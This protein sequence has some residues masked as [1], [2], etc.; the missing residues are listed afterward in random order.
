M[1][2]MNYL[3]TVMLL[4]PLSAWALNLAEPGVLMA[5]AQKNR[6]ELREVLLDIDMN[7]PEM[8]DQPTFEKYFYLL[9]SLN[10]LAVKYNLDEIYPKM[11]P[12]LGLRMTGNGMRWLDVTK[13]SSEKLQYY[14][15]WMDAD[16]LSRFLDN[17]TYNLTLIK[18]RGSLAVMAT[19]IESILPL[20]DAKAAGQTHLM[21]GYRRLLTDVAIA[22]LRDKTLPAD[23]VN[24]WIGK[25][26]LPSSIAEYTDYLS[27]DIYQLNGENKSVAPLY[28][29]RLLL[30]S[31]Q[32]GNLGSA[33][34]QWLANSLG[35]AVT[36]L[37]LRS[38][39]LEIVFS[40]NQYAQGLALLSG[41]QTIG[42][43]QQLMAQEKPPRTQFVEQYLTL[44]NL[45]IARL[46]SLGLT[47]D[48]DL[49]AKWLAQT[50]APIMAQK[51]NLEGHYALV[52]ENGQP[53]FFTVALAK[54]NMLVAALADAEGMVFKNFYNISFNLKDNGF[55]ASERE[56]DSDGPQNPPAKF[57]IN[58]KGQI[59]LTDIFVRVGSGRFKGQKVQNFTDIWA[60]AKKDA[61]V[62]DG[63]YEGTM[64]LPSG[65]ESKTRLI[66]TSFNGYTTGR[67]EVDKVDIDL[68][69]GTA[70]DDGAITLTSGRKQGASWL[71]VRA[72]IT[73]KGLKAY[74]IVGGKGQGTACTFLKKVN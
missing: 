68:N 54:E 5:K 42:F 18:D 62:P 46:K 30:L 4:S 47:K 34:P 61:P 70:G 59:Q 35:D 15:K 55:V 37:L 50:A 58:E 21:S 9:D 71:Q 19:N 63:I 73:E 69:I 53:W 22:T 48:A 13:D 49:H 57:T 43:S 10:A 16:V 23:E 1:K 24:F 60:S 6:I 28:L 39:R 27:Q 12:R 29:N 33:A 25:L 8:R 67:L 52:D 65:T 17:T 36:E 41:R 74:L 44:S 26:M 14:V 45:L 72:Q 2:I 38:V 64:F 51:V 66:I 32:V 11:V 20:V 3:L 31:V 56:P 40:A 7:I